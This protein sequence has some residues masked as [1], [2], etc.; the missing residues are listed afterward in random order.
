MFDRWAAGANDIDT[1]LLHWLRWG[2]PAGIDESIP[3]VGV[4]PASSAEPDREFSMQDFDA[5]HIN[6]QSME[7]SPHGEEVLKDLESKGFVK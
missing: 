1:P 5:N 3:S 6:Y 4:F 2:A 7:D